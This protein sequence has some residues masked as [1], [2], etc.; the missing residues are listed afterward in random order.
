MDTSLSLFYVLA[1]F[2]VSLYLTFKS[3][4]SDRFVS[5]MV[6]FWILAHSVL[7]A[8]IFTIKIGGLPFD[9]Q[10]SRIYFLLFLSYLMFLFLRN[11]VRKTERIKILK[12]EFVLIFYVIVSIFVSYMHD[13]DV[14][15][16]R[17]FVLRNIPI[18]SFLLF[19]LILKKTADSQ[20]IKVLIKSLLILC[21]VSSL[22][23]IYQML[24]N[25]YFFRMGEL[26]SAYA[27]YFR[28]TGV[29]SAEYTQSYFLVSG[30][31]LALFTV[32][33]RILRRFLLG[34]YF[35]GILF[36]FHRMSWIT[37]AI[38]FILFFIV[39]KKEFSKM[40]A[41]GT[42][43]A[44]LAAFLFIILA[45]R[46]QQFKGTALYQSRFTDRTMGSRMR[47]NKMIFR[48]IHKS[49]LIG[50]GSRESDMYY[51]GMLEAAVGIEWARGKVG[52]IHNGFLIEL[53]FKGVIVFILYILFFIFAFDYFRYLA[54]FKHVVFYF[55]VFELTKFVLANM[56]NGFNLG[57][58]LGLFLAMVLG[59]SVAINIRGIHAENEVFDQVPP[60]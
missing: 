43:A 19:Y 37:L 50:F 13:R 58:S 33:S 25:Q 49:W 41:V 3:G 12:Y 27:G 51:F 20:M 44:V 53:F 32:P 31:I 8:D 36:T 30:L 57:T 16:G 1:A 40:M 2:S 29:F 23:G 52:G 48:N 26:R 39:V 35:V 17:E 24:G 21:S 38:L 56:T 18:L 22:I 11:S 6:S 47:I 7:G 14:V 42:S 45:P 5:F 54:R 46:I 60:K 10:P 9:L 15:S 4:S 55:A 59:V 28:S 34:L